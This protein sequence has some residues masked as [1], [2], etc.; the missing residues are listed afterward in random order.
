M[1]VRNVGGVVWK[2]PQSFGSSARVYREGT[3]YLP[4]FVDNEGHR[5]AM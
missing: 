1:Y 4:F 5:S 3:E 2:E